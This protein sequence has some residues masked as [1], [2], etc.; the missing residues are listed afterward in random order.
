[1]SPHQFVATNYTRDYGPSLSFFIVLFAGIVSHKMM[2]MALSLVFPLISSLQTEVR[3]ADICV[4]PR[5][6][7]VGICMFLPNIYSTINIDLCIFSRA[8]VM[9]MH[10]SIL[11]PTWPQPPLM[12]LVVLVLGRDIQEAFVLLFAGAPQIVLRFPLLARDAS[13]P[14]RVLKASI[15]SCFLHWLSALHYFMPQAGVRSVGE[16]PH[17]LLTF[18]SC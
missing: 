5:T 12:I 1:M 18:C 4:F 14:I 6:P 15:L 11:L 2:A 16:D 9:P 17:E 7:S 8:F 3:V 10:T 13:Q